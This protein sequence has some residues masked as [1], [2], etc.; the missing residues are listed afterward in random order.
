MKLLFVLVLPCLALPIPSHAS[1]SSIQGGITGG[2]LGLSIAGLTPVPQKLLTIGTGIV[3]GSTIGYIYGTAQDVKEKRTGVPA[4]VISSAVGVSSLVSNT[5]NSAASASNS[6]SSAAV[7]SNSTTLAAVGTNSTLL[8]AV[9]NNSTT[10]PTTV[11]STSVPVVATSDSNSLPAFVASNS[12]SGTHSNSPVIASSVLPAILKS[13]AAVPVTN[14]TT[15]PVMVPVATAINATT[16]QISD[17]NKDT[18][19]VL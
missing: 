7:G 9:G 18:A 8:A 19:A 2:M 14:S 3:V 13:V 12:T 1:K 10:M 16:L 5:K 4:A 6:T 17:K 15:P 11:S